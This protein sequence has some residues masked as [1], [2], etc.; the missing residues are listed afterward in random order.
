MARVNRAASDP[1]FEPIIGRTHE[2]ALIAQALR[3]A[4]LTSTLVLLEGPAG[5]GKSTL[6][7]RARRDGGQSGFAIAFG[8]ATPESA[9]RPFAPL[10]DALDFDDPL[11]LSQADVNQV[12][13]VFAIAA[14]LRYQMI[15][16]ICTHVEG[17]SLRRPLAIVIEDL[18]AGESSTVLALRSLRQRLDGAPV[19]ILAST[20]PVVG[21][22]ELAR[23]MRSLEQSADEVIVLEPLNEGQS[24]EMAERACGEPLNKRRRA[25]TALGSGN[26]LMIR[27]VLRDNAING[28]I[29]KSLS[30]ALQRSVERRLSAL[31]S[32]QQRVVFAAAV[33]GTH[34]LL[35]N[36]SPVSGFDEQLVRSALIAARDQHLV[37]LEESTRTANSATISKAVFVHDVIRDIVHAIMPPTLRTEFH[38]R[39][40]NVI[41]DVGG[42]ASTVAWHLSEQMLQGAETIDQRRWLLQAA[43][44]AAGRAP[45][46]SARLY[47]D[48][49]EGVSLLDDNFFDVRLELL[50]QLTSAGLFDDAEKHGRQLLDCDISVDQELAVRW[51]LGSVFFVNYRLDEA[52]ELTAPSAMRKASA[53]TQARLHALTA[54]IQACRLDPTFVQ[55]VDIAMELALQIQDPSALAI[56]TVL[57]ARAAANNLDLPGA[58]ALSEEAVRI[59]DR[60]SDGLAHRYQPLFFLALRLIDAHDLASSSRVLVT[61]HRQSQRSGTS[62]AESLYCA[63]EALI[64]LRGGRLDDAFA[65]ACASLAIAD[66]TGVYVTAIVARCVCASVRMLRGDLDGAAE[67]LSI[68]EGYSATDPLRFGSE[69]L[70]AT[71]VRLH[72]ARNEVETALTLATEVATLFT[73]VGFRIGALEMYGAGLSTI[74]NVNSDVTTVETGD[75]EQSR[76]SRATALEAAFLYTVEGVPS[77]PTIEALSAWFAAVGAPSMA[78]WKLALA[79][80]DQGLWIFERQAVRFAALKWALENGAVR[81]FTMLGEEIEMLELPLTQDQQKLIARLRKMLMQPRKRVAATPGGKSRLSPTERLVGAAIAEGKSNREIAE[82]LHLSVRTVE[83]HVASLL[84]KLSVTSRVHVALSMKANPGRL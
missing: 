84:R 75:V 19:L 38:G 39:A 63:G 33:F 49:L 77:T 8:H 80:C 79:T 17:G 81:E 74:A 20:R 78:S 67:E 48:A 46:V 45:N 60:D 4:K 21:G 44:D 53:Q 40:A 82:S 7:A 32:E 11:S 68:A 16:S 31:D 61:G 47:L 56:A 29:P 26:P 70:M 42:P 28:P 50:G 10:L 51:W 43:R 30:E 41:V 3:R 76:I 23:S 18:H 6:V 59:A 5:I 37:L 24:I 27:E 58:I 1:A 65:D 9:G 62:W 2:L 66:D 22:S 12:G 14:D 25:L 55:T 71:K 35:A 36:L 34:F 73:A 15:E 52:Q 64:A 69:V 54:L 83:S 57:A 13:A 72:S